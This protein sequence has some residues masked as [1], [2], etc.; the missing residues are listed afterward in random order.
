MWVHVGDTVR[1]RAQVA[2]VADDSAQYDCGTGVRRSRVPRLVHAPSAGLCR[3][4]ALSVCSIIS[5]TLN[6]KP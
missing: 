4:L 2:H 6:L 5:P 3:P 1:V